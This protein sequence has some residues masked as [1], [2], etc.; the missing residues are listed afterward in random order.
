MEAE[1]TPASY[2]LTLD[3]VSAQ[4]SPHRFLYNGT[5]FVT[6]LRK[7]ELPGGTCYAVVA[8]RASRPCRLPASAVVTPVT[9]VPPPHT[10]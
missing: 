7:E 8:R 9:P 3:E 5:I 6:I 10:L 2:S 1:W 4:A